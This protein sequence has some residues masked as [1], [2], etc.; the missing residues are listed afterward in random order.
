MTP[1]EERKMINSSLKSWVK[2][3]CNFEEAYAKVFHKIHKLEECGGEFI[4]LPSCQERR[5]KAVNLIYAKGEPMTL[6]QVSD[7]LGI[8]SKAMQHP[9]IQLAKAGRLDKASRGEG[10]LTLFVY[11][12]PRVVSEFKGRHGAVSKRIKEIMELLKTA[13]RDLSV[14]ELSER[15]DMDHSL[16]KNTV[17]YMKQ[18]RL[19]K[20]LPRAKG[21]GKAGQ[22]AATY[23]IAEVT[24]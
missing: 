20:I 10:S 24:K 5:E 15:L 11:S 7:A 3:G 21:R 9:L 19:I 22:P 16:V 6:R 23:L 18:D 1:G 12:K 17:H 4:A 8:P 14:F 13:G 2:K